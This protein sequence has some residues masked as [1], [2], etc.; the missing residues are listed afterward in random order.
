MSYSVAVVNVGA[1]KSNINKIKGSLLKGVKYCAVVKSDAYGH[2]I[3]QTSDAIEPLVDFF[4]VSFLEE[5]IQLRYSGIKKPVLILLPLKNGEMETA[6]RYGLSVTV[7]SVEKAKFISEKRLNAKV[8]IAVNTG[9]NRLGIDCVEQLKIISLLLKRNPLC[10]VEGIFSHFY[11]EDIDLCFKQYKKFC[12]FCSVIKRTNSNVIRHICASNCLNLDKKYQLDMVRV[13]V[14]MYGYSP[15]SRVKTTPA[16][17][18]YAEKIVDRTI[19]KNENV[20]YGEYVLQKDEKVSIIKYGY[21]D[22]AFREEL[23]SLNNRCMDL[24][25]VKQG[26]NSTVVLDD[27]ERIARLYGTIPYEILVSFSKRSKK[28]Y[29]DYEDN[30]RKK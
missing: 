22:G 8:H 14:A 25:C 17:K 28:I 9:M 11:S 29:R 12:K 7:D 26:K 10:R 21:A 16:M 18:I 15:S 4:A 27:A 30:S 2:G 5:G 3:S 20:L 1:I 24:S 13:G 6:T 19:K 23:C